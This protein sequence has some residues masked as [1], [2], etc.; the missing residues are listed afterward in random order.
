MFPD[1]RVLKDRAFKKKSR[2]EYNCEKYSNGKIEDLH[3][4]I[5]KKIF[6]KRSNEF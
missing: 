3:F 5:D 2:I 4:I 1:L 6:N